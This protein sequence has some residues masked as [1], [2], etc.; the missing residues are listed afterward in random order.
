MVFFLHFFGLPQSKNGEGY[1]RL[2]QGKMDFGYKDPKTLFFFFVGMHTVV[3]TIAWYA[4]ALDAVDWVGGFVEN[5]CLS[6]RCSPTEQPKLE[7]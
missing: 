7:L 5:S 3:A 2:A 1:K 4:P 6:R